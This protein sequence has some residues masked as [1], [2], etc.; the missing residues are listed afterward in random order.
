MGRAAQRGQSHPHDDPSPNSY[1]LHPPMAPCIASVDHH[2]RRGTRGKMSSRAHR[3]AIPM[4]AQCCTL[5]AARQNSPSQA[6]SPGESITEGCILRPQRTGIK[7]AVHLTTIAS[8]AKITIAGVFDEIFF[9]SG[10]TASVRTLACGAGT[11]H[12]LIYFLKVAFIL[13]SGGVLESCAH[14][15]MRDDYGRFPHKYS[16]G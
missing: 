11:S 9:V 12:I 1:R 14:P 15:I 8:T 2:A 13:T 3:A 7:S 5:A 4:P 10:R 6:P 16:A